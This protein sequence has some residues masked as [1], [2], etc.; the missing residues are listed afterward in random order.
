MHPTRGCTHLLP[1]SRSPYT[2]IHTATYL[3]RQ[4]S[5]V[6]RCLG[7]PFLRVP[8]KGRQL[9]NPTQA[10]NRDISSRV[11]HAH[12]ICSWPYSQSLRHTAGLCIRYLVDWFLQH[13]RLIPCVPFDLWPSADDVDV[14]TLTL[15][16]VLNG[17][18]GWVRALATDGRWLFRCSY[19]PTNL[20][21]LPFNIHAVLLA[22][23]R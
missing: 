21:S 14:L 3:L 17:H 7:A 1:G 10:I 2:G 12:C 8:G 9:L 19:T 5:Q 4:C 22:H 11:D 18:S 15:Q 16:V 23:N 20:L 6:C 13:H